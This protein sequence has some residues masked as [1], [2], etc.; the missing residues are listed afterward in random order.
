MSG[1]VRV[2]ASRMRV[3]WVV[4]VLGLATISS[5][6]VSGAPLS[7]SQLDDWCTT[8]DSGAMRAVCGV[9]FSGAVDAGLVY[10]TMLEDTGLALYCAPADLTA[11]IAMRVGQRHV[12]ENPETLA[13]PAAAHPI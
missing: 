8:G 2:V 1:Y 12:E 3:L 7:A 5:T 13:E 6:H 4:F 11:N 9:W 10:G